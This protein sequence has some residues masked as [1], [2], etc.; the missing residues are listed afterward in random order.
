M[1][2]NKTFADRLSGLFRK[3]V[4]KANK[5]DKS[6]LVMET[7]GE[8][9]ID[10]EVIDEAIGKS[11]AIEKSFL[12][13]IYDENNCNLSGEFLAE[14]EYAK[15]EIANIIRR[16]DAMNFIPLEKMQESFFIDYEN[17][18]LDFKDREVA[19]EQKMVENLNFLSNLS[20]LASF[21]SPKI[22]NSEL[23]I[24]AEK[25]TKEGISHNIKG[26]S[27]AF[28]APKENGYDFLQFSEKDDNNAMLYGLNYKYNDTQQINFESGDIES[29]G[30][31]FNESVEVQEA[32][33][34]SLRDLD[35]VFDLELKGIIDIFAH[36]LQ[37]QM[38]LDN[39]SNTDY[40]EVLRELFTAVY[41]SF[42][43]K[44]AESIKKDQTNQF[45]K[46]SIN[47][48]NLRSF[49]SNTHAMRAL[50]KMKLYDMF[51]S[52]MRF[53][54]D[55]E[56]GFSNFVYNSNASISR[57]IESY[58]SSKQSVFKRQLKEVETYDFLLRK[59]SAALGPEF[60]FFAI[61]KEDKIKKQFAI[62]F[63][64]K[65]ALAKK[66]DLEK[67][68]SKESILK[69]FD[70]GIISNNAK[71][72]LL[73]L[74]GDEKISLLTKAY[75]YM[76]AETGEVNEIEIFDEVIESFKIASN[77]IE[78]EVNRYN[79]AL[80]N[81]PKKKDIDN[82]ANLDDNVTNIVPIATFKTVNSDNYYVVLSG[83]TYNLI[84]ENEIVLCTINNY[85]FSSNL[86]KII[87][88]NIFEQTGHK[89]ATITDNFGKTST[90]EPKEVK[91]GNVETVNTMTEEMHY[92]NEYNDFFD[93]TPTEVFI[94]E[95]IP[96]NIAEE[97]EE[98][99]KY[100]IK[101]KTFIVNNLGEINIVD[102]ESSAV[103]NINSFEIDASM[104]VYDK[105]LQLILGKKLVE[106]GYLKE[107]LS[108]GTGEEQLSVLAPVRKIDFE[109]SKELMAFLNSVHIDEQ[110][111]IW[112]LSIVKKI[113]KS[114]DDNEQ[115]K[116][117]GLGDFPIDSSLQES[118]IKHYMEEMEEKDT[119]K[120]SVQEKNVEESAKR[121]PAIN[122][123][124]GN[125][126][127]EDAVEQVVAS[128]QNTPPVTMAEQPQE[129]ALGNVH[130]D[131]SD[132]EE[133]RRKQ[134]T[135][136]DNNFS[137]IA[138]IA[139]LKNPY[140]VVK[141]LIEN[142]ENITNFSSYPARDGNPQ[143]EMMQFETKNQNK[144][145]A[146][147]RFSVQFNIG[148]TV[149]NADFNIDDKEKSGKSP[150]YQWNVF[151][152]SS[153]ADKI[154]RFSG[155]DFVSFLEK[156]GQTD[157][158]FKEKIETY[159]KYDNSLRDKTK[160]ELNGSIGNYLELNKKVNDLR[161]AVPSKEEL[162][163]KSKLTIDELTSID[164]V[165]MLE[166]LSAVSGIKIK[167][168]G[169]HFMLGS[170]KT[171]SCCIKN[172]G[173]TY[174]GKDFGSSS[175]YKGTILNVAMISEK[176]DKKEA[177]KFFI[178]R[179]Y[180]TDHYGNYLDDIASENELKLK[181]TLGDLY[182]MSLASEVKIVDEEEKLKREEALKALEEDRARKKEEQLKKENEAF[183]AK[184]TRVL[185]ATKNYSK[186]TKEFLA[187]RGIYGSINGL[188][189]MI[190]ERYYSNKE[191]TFTYVGV[192]VI[193]T[194]IGKGMEFAGMLEL[195]ENYINL[196][197]QETKSIKSIAAICDLFIVFVNIL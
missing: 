36:R 60:D 73:K 170:E 188:Y 83:E 186:E 13:D 86:N 189:E 175:D 150:N 12:L 62:D 45:I 154:K 158:S 49:I 37:T 113:N 11:L 99:E 137:E 172:S 138:K 146:S 82:N 131:S 116:Y 184:P 115:M 103:D 66:K 16:L 69:D 174:L 182:N 50:E 30:K 76:L 94:E 178:D 196:E 72:K 63:K 197:P 194:E 147:K 2:F 195:E 85:V 75:V 107:V 80:L 89:V 55:L 57:I 44:I 144:K 7:I 1:I 23:V 163:A 77:T 151:L 104:G 181:E 125:H 143:L 141:T 24:F 98:V 38:K 14:G 32:I 39:A 53:Q 33:L 180:A 20:M 26:L 48:E 47:P 179:N 159:L 123:E 22:S 139:N 79:E 61:G 31:R 35:R 177:I 185:Y 102:K 142:S 87:E 90:N 71:E 18:L 25:F 173:G 106:D 92:S 122:S 100:A 95:E 101:E 157:S 192:G 156:N 109:K 96:E 67:A 133:P 43:A 110:K 29:Q 117:I 93:T 54:N 34:K 28:L 191:G 190:V 118:I 112:F 132:K 27:E 78:R 165:P 114:F 130:S 155:L 148:E 41:Q 6:L 111:F 88:E 91:L 17:I 169:I 42:L 84:D 40:G 176:M 128:N 105:R 51:K 162:A 124:L 46:S 183:D 171:A 65:L 70:Y 59:V 3:S 121:E 187:K 81:N 149:Y 153:E 58:H 167:S 161:L 164:P 56:L 145:L 19:N 52:H 68:F 108:A 97:V 4:N 140:F 160:E 134:N 120:G 21:N 127:E 135:K 166:D 168:S 193:S 8:E 74:S 136:Y 129:T 126:T 15:T 10:V 5:E 64:K 152:K 9:I 119:R